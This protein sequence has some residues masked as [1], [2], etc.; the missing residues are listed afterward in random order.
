[1]LEFFRCQL[2][3][4]NPSLNLYNKFKEEFN[5]IYAISLPEL[6]L[7]HIILGCKLSVTNEQLQNFSNI[8]ICWEKFLIL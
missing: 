7:P 2:Y 4:K 5:C 1:M 3:K 8:N 6:A